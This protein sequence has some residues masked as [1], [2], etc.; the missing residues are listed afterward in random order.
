M[1]SKR[2]LLATSVAKHRSSTRFHYTMSLVL[3]TAFEFSVESDTR[4][5]GGGEQKPII[6]QDFA[7]SS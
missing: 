5:G 2:K 7:E 6:W 4:K 3:I 1:R